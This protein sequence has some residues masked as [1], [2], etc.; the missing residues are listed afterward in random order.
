[1][2]LD[3]VECILTVTLNPALDQTV[4]IPRFYEGKTYA[5]TG[6]VPAAGGKGVNVSRALHN[7]K[8]KTCAL[9]LLG[10]ITGETFRRLLVRE[11][12]THDFVSVEG[13]TRTNL[14]I[15][16]PQSRSRTR[17]LEP[18]PK[19]SMAEIRRFK[20]VY[21]AWLK[22]SCFVVV[23]GRNACGAP[24][25]LYAD[26]IYLA[27]RENV[28]SILDTSGLSLKAGLKAKPFMVKLNVEEAQEILGVR[29]DTLPRLKKAVG[30]FH[31]LGVGMVVI[32]MNRDGALGSD[33]RE[34][35]YGRP[36]KIRVKNDVGCGDALMGGFLYAYLRRRP[37]REVI[38]CAVAAGTANALTLTPGNICR[39]DFNKFSKTVSVRRL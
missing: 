8:L 32:S 35:W 5:S 31:R 37:F 30:Q 18:G 16:D 33:S 34:M 1:M 14:T 23:S 11:R 28:P 27:K 3:S 4:T 21:K 2:K 20:K 7:L 17:I 25:A 15:V 24:D 38:R 29:L 36:P 9:G 22:R 13:E 12:I 39:E 19:V 6:Q 10:G 26:L